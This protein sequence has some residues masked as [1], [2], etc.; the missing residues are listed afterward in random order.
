MCKGLKGEYAKALRDVKT[1]FPTMVCCDA[2]ETG[3]CSHGKACEC[4]GQQAPW[5]WIVNG[6]CANF[7]NCHTEADLRRAWSKAGGYKYFH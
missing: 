1:A 2:F 4:G 6:A 5:P 7:C 3:G